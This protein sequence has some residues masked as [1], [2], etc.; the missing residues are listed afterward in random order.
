MI[1]RLFNAG[2]TSDLA[3]SRRNGAYAL[4]I[5]QGYS[6]YGNVNPGD[7]ETRTRNYQANG[8]EVVVH[9]KAFWKNGTEDSRMKAIL[10]RPRKQ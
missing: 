9:D 5:K 4:L 1:E 8:L 2:E 6:W 10:V 3:V 7:V